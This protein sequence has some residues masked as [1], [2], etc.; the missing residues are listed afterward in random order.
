M[1]LKVTIEPLTI[2]D[3]L[4]TFVVHLRLAAR[5]MRGFLGS[6]NGNGVDR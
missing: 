2:V 4:A 1:A 5:S 6:S 3:H